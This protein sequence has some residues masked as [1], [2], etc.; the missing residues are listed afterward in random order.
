MYN[1]S[2][3]GFSELRLLELTNHGGRP[4]RERRSSVVLTGSPPSP[5]TG[6]V[7]ELRG[8]ALPDKRSSWK[9]LFPPNLEREGLIFVFHAS[10]Y[11]Y[12]IAAAK[13]N[14]MKDRFG[15][16]INYL[17]VSVTDRCN[18]R[19]V[20][21]MPPEGVPL[22]NHED[23]LRYEEILTVLAVAKQLGISH[24]R[25][26]GGE[27]LVRKNLD[28]LVRGIA[29]MGFEDIAMTTNG[30]LLTDYAQTLKDAGLMRV[31]VSLD[32]LRPD[33]FSRITRTGRI[34]DALA[35]IQAAVQ[36]GLLPVK[37][38]VVVMAGWNLDEVADIARL[39]LKMPVHVRFIEYMPVGPSDGMEEVSGVSS[40]LI[41][42]EISKTL[43]GKLEVST[44]PPGAGP[45]RTYRSAGAK[46]T[47]GFISAMSKPFCDSCN[48]LRLT[49][50]GK[51]RPCLASAI[52]VDVKEILRGSRQGSKIR[53]IEEAFKR[54]VLCKPRAHEEWDRESRGRRMCQMGG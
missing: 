42:A 3:Q 47:I 43:P 54:A 21:C 29:A 26:T 27:P 51:L 40:D 31:N 48:R 41:M 6:A 22:L 4:S 16:E 10:P 1:G 18:L 9:R 53:E 38:N 5:G 12:G 13:E 30:T 49:P 20:Y 7:P 32:S 2:G 14:H 34:E 23:I 25:L 35:G 24:V 37:V 11:P 17:R 46:G 45:A 8:A 44:A 33:R 19:C 36:A 52:E 50:D 39:T 28:Q 15:R